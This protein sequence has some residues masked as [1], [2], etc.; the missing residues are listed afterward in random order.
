LSDSLG[1]HHICNLLKALDR[2]STLEVEISALGQR[3]ER[4]NYRLA[5]CAAEHQQV[6][7]LVREQLNHMNM[8]ATDSYGYAERFERLLVLLADTDGRARG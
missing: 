3:I 1:S 5:E 6:W 2:V 4:Q 8:V 7:I